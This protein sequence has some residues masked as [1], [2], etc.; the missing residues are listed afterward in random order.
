VSKGCRGGTRGVESVRAGVEMYTGD[1]GEISRAYAW[2][3]KVYGIRVSNVRTR[4]VGEQEDMR[5]GV[6]NRQ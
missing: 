2:E 1:K 4:A 6:R 5:V 3:L